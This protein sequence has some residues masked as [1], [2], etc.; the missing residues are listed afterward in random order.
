MLKPLAAVFAAGFLYSCASSNDTMDTTA[1]DETTTMSETTTMAGDD[2]TTETEVSTDVTTNTDMDTAATMDAT[3]ET[4]SMAILDAARTKSE[5]STF[6]ELIQ[7]AN[8]SAAFDQEG[9]FTIFAPNNEAFKQL[10]AGQL[11][12]LKKP[13]NRN[14]LIQVLQAHIISGKVTTAQL[15]TNQRI[16]VGEDD[17]IEVASA[18]ANPTAF[19]IGGASIVDSDIEAN[20]GVIHVVDRVLVTADRVTDEK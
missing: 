18:G 15:Q 5:I 17:Y 7:A 16:Q 14:E 8:I 12:Y 2:V 11:E 19:T 10:P 1:M 20:N 13:E 4:S 3:A 9:E 6:M